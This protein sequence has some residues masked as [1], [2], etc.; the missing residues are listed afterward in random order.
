MT[1]IT[2]PAECHARLLE[3]QSDRLAQ[4]HYIDALVVGA[5]ARCV[6][7]QGHDGQITQRAPSQIKREFH[8]QARA[9][10]RW[11]GE[12]GSIRHV[13]L[14]A[15]L[16]L[17][18]IA[19][20][21]SDR[22]PGKSR[23]VTS[24]DA[25]YLLNVLGPIFSQRLAAAGHNRL[26]DEVLASGRSGQAEKVGEPTNGWSLFEDFILVH[27]P[28]VGIEVTKNQLRNARRDHLRTQHRQS[29]R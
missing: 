28:R 14:A 18:E 25:R 4:G 19:D 23:D 12:L 27:A 5:I 13:G 3:L 21:I 26:S 29:R 10:Q 24:K 8:S 1:I 17:G 16:R 9:F 2:E 20:G 22:K 11:Q 7:R 6:F 15:A